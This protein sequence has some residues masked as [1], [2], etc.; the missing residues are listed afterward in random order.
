VRELQGA[1][2]VAVVGADGVVELR[3]V[4]VGERVDNLW[5][6]EQG[7]RPGERVVVEGLQ[8]VRQGMKVSLEPPGGAPATAAAGTHG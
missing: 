4:T 1:Q 5:V 6:I 7:V 2:Q 8:K 3:T